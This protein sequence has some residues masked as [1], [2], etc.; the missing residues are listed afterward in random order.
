MTSSK[1]Y[2]S[3]IST[4]YRAR[5]VVRAGV[6]ARDRARAMVR[7]AKARA[8]VCFIWQFCRVGGGAEMCQF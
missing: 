8:S 4:R 2:S 3:K 6:W 5:A 1:P 7:A